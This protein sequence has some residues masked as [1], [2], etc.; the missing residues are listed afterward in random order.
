MKGIILAGGN[1]SRLYPMTSSVVKP[2]LPIYNKPMIYYPFTN[3][4]A[5]GIREIAIMSQIENTDKYKNLFGN[6]DRFG[7]KIEYLVQKKPL[8]IA[9]S[10]IIAD[11]FIGNDSVCLILG[12]N[13]FHFSNEEKIE[14]CVTNFISGATIFGYKVSNPSAYGVIEYDANNNVVSIEE[15][16]IKPKSNVASV[17][18]Y[19]YDNN[20]VQIAKNLKPSARGEL[21]ITH[22]SDSYLQKNELKVIDIGN[23]SAWLDAGLPDAMLE[24]SQFVHTLEKR[25]GISIGCPEEVALKK[26][27]ITKQQLS[28]FVGSLSGESEYKKY[29]SKLI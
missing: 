19:I 12:D 3:L 9:D 16:P 20:V 13:I 25:Q 8:G 18:L 29:L 7:V 15:K 1:G 23:G 10:F 26:G 6:G 14:A 28:D 4:L 22:I 21:E 5:L 24:A 11:D 27:Y 2:L 17:G